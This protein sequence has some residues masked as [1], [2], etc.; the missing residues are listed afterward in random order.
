MD[1]QATMETRFKPPVHAAV[2]FEIPVSDMKRAKAF[3]ATVLQTGLT[4]QD[5][6]MN[7]MAVFDIS[8]GENG[9]SGHLY[10]GRPSANGTGPTIHLPVPDSVE[11]GL[12]RVEAA[13]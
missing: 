1:A 13:G 5:G 3:Y 10:P 8:G 2:W 9:V 4:D 7:P 6:G 12:A 11:E